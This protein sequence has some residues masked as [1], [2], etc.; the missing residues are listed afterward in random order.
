[1]Y[2]LNTLLPPDSGWI[3]GSVS[4]INDKGQILADGYF[5]SAPGSEALLLTPRSMPSAVPEPSTLMMIV[6]GMAGLERFPL[7]C[8]VATGSEPAGDILM[9]HR[10]Q[11]LAHRF[12]QPAH[13]P[14]R[15]LA[16]VR[17]ELAE[18][19]LDRVEVRAVRRQVTRFG[20]RRP[21]RALDRRPLVGRQVVHH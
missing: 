4:A 15:G 8:T 13:R 19:L 12:V 11:R 21:D 9:C 20:P 17:L 3:L 1:M 14:R 2:D 16:Q 18:H 7:A 6:V 5:R 10:A